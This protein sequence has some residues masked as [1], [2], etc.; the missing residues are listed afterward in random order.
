MDTVAQSKLKRP[1]YNLPK[2]NVFFF[3]LA[4]VVFIGFRSV[5][6]GNFKIVF[7][8]MGSWLILVN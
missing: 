5:F 6:Q 1:D 4:K 8:L 2:I 3:L 7:I